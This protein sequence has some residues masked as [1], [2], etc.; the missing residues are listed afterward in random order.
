MTA[1]DA[2]VVAAFRQADE[3][4]RARSFLEREDIT[5]N[6]MPRQDA[7]ERLCPDVFAD[8]F[9]VVV[10]RTDAADAIALLQRIWPDEPTIHSEVDAHCPN[11]G[12]TDVTRV[13]RIRIFIIAALALYA[14]GLVFHQ[15]DLFVLVIAIVGASL[16]V[17]PR[18]RCR[19]CG[20]RW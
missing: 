10:A 3:A 13:P 5:A 16:M 20:E 19:T 1:S 8:G 15:R 7:L 18:S 4:S 14:G 12:S 17:I 6:M 11:C 9:D 2:V